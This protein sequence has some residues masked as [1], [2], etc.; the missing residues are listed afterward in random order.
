MVKN[1]IEQGSNTVPMTLS[2]SQMVPASQEL[3]QDRWVGSVHL[4]MPGCIP[5]IEM[6]IF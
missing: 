2:A 6:N 3:L 1:R 5:T 4:A